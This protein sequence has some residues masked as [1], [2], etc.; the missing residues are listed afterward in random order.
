MLMKLGKLR[1]ST[2]LVTALLMGGETAQACTCMAPRTA[3]EA[4]ERSSS[5]FSGRVTKISLPFLDRIGI[6]RSGNHRVEFAVR[7]H[8]KGAQSKSAVVLTRLTGETCGFPFQEGQEYLVYVAPGRGDIETGICTG[9]K[10]ITGAKLEMEQ[11][12][13][14]LKA[15]AQ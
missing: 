7:K 12:D 1:L 15:N 4:F 14:L 10:S 3:A 2:C 9:T 8:W 13:Q 11:L 6:T 5:V